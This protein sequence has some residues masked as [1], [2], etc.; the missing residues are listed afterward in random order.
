MRYERMTL[1][2]KEGG[3]RMTIDNGLGF[4]AGSITRMTPLDTFII[5]TKS[6][7]GNCL[8]DKVLRAKYLHT[9]S[10]CSK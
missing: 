6:A 2:A 8:A 5:E 1:V 3:E 10:R 9:T 4:N 7:R